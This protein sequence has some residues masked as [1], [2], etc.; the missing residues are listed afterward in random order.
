MSS[1]GVREPRK[2]VQSLS[3]L[4]MLLQRGGRWVQAPAQPRPG[5]Q[6]A[7]PRELSI[8]TC[9]LGWWRRVGQGQQAGQRSGHVQ[10]P[11]AAYPALEHRNGVNGC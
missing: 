7:T 6:G 9:R 8:L 4:A 2:A 1:A 10:A 3:P 5:G 11:A